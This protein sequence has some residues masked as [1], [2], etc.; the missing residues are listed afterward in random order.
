MINENIEKLKKKVEKDPLSKF[1]VPL[2]EEYKKEGMVE[3]A[4]SVLLTGLKNQPY[5]ISAMV[6]LGKLY[7]QKDMISEAREEFEK[8]VGLAPDNLLAHKKLAGIYY[9]R[10]EMDEALKECQSVI[11]LNPGD[12]EAK[13]MKLSLENR[14]KQAQAPEESDEAVITGSSGSPCPLRETSEAGDFQESLGTEQPVP[15][16]QGGEDIRTV[17]IKNIPVYEIDEEVNGAE[18]G[19][20]IPERLKPVDQGYV[21]RELEEFRK[22]VE[23][24]SEKPQA[25]ETSEA[26]HKEAVNMQDLLIQE[27]ETP[28]DRVDAEIPKKSGGDKI[29][30]SMRT[31]TMADIFIAQ[32][33]YDKAM[34]IYIEMLAAD[35]DNRRIIRKSEELKDLIELKNKKEDV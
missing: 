31:E 3:E 33:L 30:I 9:K 34:N 2:A 15:A 13:T 5:Y 27:V 11:K 18:L 32:G 8:A 1:F 19:I 21:T 28:E 7:L 20:K 24:H 22:I 16:S 4:M 12:N 26:Q 25:E 14:L 35:P 17:K 23:L 29:S 6:A 10:G